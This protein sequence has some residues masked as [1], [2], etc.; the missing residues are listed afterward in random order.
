MIW[1]RP[2]DIVMPRRSFDFSEIS[3]A[4]K[5]AIFVPY[6]HAVDDHQTANAN[7]LVDRQ[8]ALLIQQN[9]MNVANLTALLEPYLD[10]K[11]LIKDI[12]VKAKQAAA[13]NATQDVANLCIELSK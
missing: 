7:Y 2:V 5:M 12:A 8:A 3:A 6:P 9:E 1:I 13:L 10:N 11:A 4:G